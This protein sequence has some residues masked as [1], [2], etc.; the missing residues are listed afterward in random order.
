MTCGKVCQCCHFKISGRKSLSVWAKS[1]AIKI[2]WDLCKWR[3][4]T[5]VDSVIVLCARVHVTSLYCIFQLQLIFAHAC[6]WL[7]SR[8][9]FTIISC[10]LFTLTMRTGILSFFSKLKS[11]YSSWHE[12]LKCLNFIWNVKRSWEC[13]NHCTIFIGPDELITRGNDA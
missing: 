12:I 11:N 13:F 9:Y 6:Y 1:Y 8:F 5:G 7:L 2:F 3:Q 4:P 10:Y